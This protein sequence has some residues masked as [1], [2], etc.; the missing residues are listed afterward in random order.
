MMNV[1]ESHPE[2][3]G[4]H[5]P[6]PL[7]VSEATAARMCG[8]SQAVFR[9]WTDQGRLHAVVVGVRRNLYRVADIRAFA[10]GLPRA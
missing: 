4:H 9:R 6:D 5:E 1:V 7:L 8:V 3:N 2:G 10:D